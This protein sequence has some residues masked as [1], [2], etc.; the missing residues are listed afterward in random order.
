MVNI[1]F[2]NSLLPERRIHVLLPQAKSAWPKYATQQAP[3]AIM[4]L[5]LI[6]H[7]KAS[8]TQT[9]NLRLLLLQ[10]QTKDKQKR[11]K[12]ELKYMKWKKK[13]KK[14]INSSIKHF[15]IIIFVH[16]SQLSEF[17]IQTVHSTK[18]TRNFP[19]KLHNPVH[20]TTSKV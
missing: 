18:F 7:R 14:K 15:I 11:I 17:S 1:Y 5:G 3:N 12:I 19:L 13:K 8:F 9:P 4:F 6:I 2:V 10:T 20:K 16:L